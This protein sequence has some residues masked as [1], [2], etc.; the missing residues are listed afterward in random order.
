MRSCGRGVFGVAPFVAIN[1]QLQKYKTAIFLK[2]NYNKF[3]D[4]VTFGYIYFFATRNLFSSHKVT[5]LK[6]N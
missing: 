3:L 4:S 6:I 1:E 2:N 5:Y